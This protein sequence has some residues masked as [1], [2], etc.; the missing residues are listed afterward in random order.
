MSS[1][2]K[3]EARPRAVILCSFRPPAYLNY[4]FQFKRYAPLYTRPTRIDPPVLYRV[5]RVYT[6]YTRG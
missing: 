1:H 6:G 2:V 5:Y 4:R 3:G